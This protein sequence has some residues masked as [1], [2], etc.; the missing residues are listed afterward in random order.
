MF[1]LALDKSTDTTNTA[2]LLVFIRGVSTESGVTEELVSMNSLHGITK[3]EDIMKEV[4][5]T[6]QF[7][8]ESVKMRQNI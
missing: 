3:S 5:K 8:M 1:S 2:Q 7:A 4:E 6:M